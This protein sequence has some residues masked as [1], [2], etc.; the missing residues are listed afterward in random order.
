MASIN[1]AAWRSCVFFCIL[2][3]AGCNAMAGSSLG[4]T[5][6]GIKDL[7]VARSLVAEG[8]LPSADMIV[9]EGMLSEHDLPLPSRPCTN[10]LCLSAAGGV[11]NTIDGPRSGWVQ[12]G[13]SSSID[14][15]SFE[16]DPIAAVMVVDVSGSM[17]WGAN[18]ESPGELARALL[19]RLDVELD[20]HDRVNIVTYGS[21]AS[22]QLGWVAG[23][24]A[25]IASVISN[26]EEDGST[27]ME[28]GVRLAYEQASS[29]AEEGFQQR[30][31]LFTDENPNV[32]AVEASAFESMV[33]NGASE[34][35]GMTVFGLGGSLNEST[36]AAMSHVRLA[37]AYSAARLDDVTAI[38]EESW[39]WM[40]A[41]IARDLNIKLRTGD[42]ISV[43]ATYG[44]PQGEHPH[45]VEL[46]VSTVFLSRKNGALLVRLD[47]DDAAA[48]AGASVHATIV[49]EDLLA[50][51][52]SESFDVTLPSAEDAAP[53]FEAPSTDEA[54]ALALMADGLHDALELDDSAQREALCVDLLARVH[55]DAARIDRPDF[56]TE[57]Q[58]AEALVALIRAQ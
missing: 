13:L 11:A 46:S 12:I 39:P 30:L 56:D 7:R 14:M 19:R 3:G 6:G 34:G 26:L 54:V 50:G 9:V 18:A 53:V 41:P 10:R 4:A 55:E 44:M 27:N 42:D 37:N 25:R 51:H 2:I 36:M 58:F 52:M 24:D 16:R 22:V 5:P 43:G 57:V 28:A 35:V 33:A 15:E 1:R 29:F 20:E 45:E 47:A 8:R 23:N 31:F 21:R 40:A 38:F 48:L 49:Y 32:G 17:G